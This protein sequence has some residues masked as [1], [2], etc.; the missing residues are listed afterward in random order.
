M[1]LIGTYR[2]FHP[3]AAQYTFLSIAHGSF[4]KIDHILG[5]KASLNKY[6]KVEMMALSYQKT[7]E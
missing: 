3:V 4:S 2:L 5:H 6:K 1:D 7:M